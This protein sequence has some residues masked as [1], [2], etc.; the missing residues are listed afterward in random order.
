MSYH[1]D[2]DTQSRLVNTLRKYDP[3]RVKAEKR[4]KVDKR[5]E[6][7]KVNMAKAREAKLAGLRARKEKAQEETVE[8][9][10]EEEE[11]SDNSDDSE[12]EDYEYVPKPKIVQKGKAK[13]KAK[14]E[15]PPPAADA[16]IDK[17]TELLE[18]MMT[19]TQVKKKKKAPVRKTII[20]VTAPSAAAASVPN[21]KAADMKKNVESWW[22]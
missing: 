20:Q 6:S 4:P 18:K 22:G 11:N 7:S 12:Y 2:D 1:S 17:L 10:E 8:E 13:T 16:R 21:P 19:Q 5:S 14:V 15:T 3:T 9:S